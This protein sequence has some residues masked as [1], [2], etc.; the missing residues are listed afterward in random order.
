MNSQR[1]SKGRPESTTT[2]HEE[3]TVSG[4]SGNSQS[5]TEA[6]HDDKH[7]VRSDSDS[8]TEQKDHTGV[9]V[10]RDSEG[11]NDSEDEEK[12][13][14][15][16]KSEYD[17]VGACSAK[18]SETENSDVENDDVVD[19]KG[20]ENEHENENVEEI[21]EH[22]NGEHSENSN[23][24]E[25]DTVKAVEAIEKQRNKKESENQTSNKS[26]AAGVKDFESE[27]KNFVGDSQ[28]S[29]TSVGTGNRKSANKSL[30]TSRH[31]EVDSHS[32][33][34]SNS[35][36]EQES[37]IKSN[38][39]LTRRKG[40]NVSHRSSS[41]TGKLRSK[42]QAEGDVEKDT[43]NEEHALDK[44]R[45]KRSQV[46]KKS[47]SRNESNTSKRSIQDESES[48]SNKSFKD[49]KQSTR[50]GKDKQKLET[51][52]QTVQNDNLGNAD[53]DHDSND[54]EK[55]SDHH[56]ADESDEDSNVED[57]QYDDERTEKDRSQTLQMD[58]QADE[59]QNEELQSDEEEEEEEIEYDDAEDDIRPS[60]TGIDVAG[61]RSGSIT[62]LE[63]P[64]TSKVSF[65]RTR[66]R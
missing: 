21:S 62:K 2:A 27:F 40:A 14:N 35:E 55:Q 15:H 44:S 57:D 23:N 61:N 48:V 52:A 53:D 17:K 19:S 5:S 28:K 8:E 6:V 3:D 12:I 30:K 24:S 33:G 38:T 63:A 37:I 25:E 47:L 36:D 65:D 51:N 32:H 54:D 20:L 16:E 34:E 1:R 60:Q 50:T 41:G 56:D 42:L 7:D 64:D 66:K 4:N 9:G 46:S 58:R 29:R 10:D 43:S 22:E 49:R 45:S 11:K 26:K 13:D 18:N 59:Q 31:S 39:K